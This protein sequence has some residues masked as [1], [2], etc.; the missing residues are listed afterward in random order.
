MHQGGFEPSTA[1]L[2]LTT[3]PVIRDITA[4]LEALEKGCLRVS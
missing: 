1:N 3:Q 2:L 4:Q